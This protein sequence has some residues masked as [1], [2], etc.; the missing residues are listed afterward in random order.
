MRPWIVALAVATALSLAACGEGEEAGG[1][2][3]AA[4]AEPESFTARGSLKLTSGSVE[5]AGDVCYGSD[6]F[7]DIAGGAQVVV[8]DAAGESV[9]LGEL[10]EGTPAGAVQCVFTF[11]VRDVPA[12]DSVY[13][14]EVAG[15]GEVSFTPDEAFAL[16]LTLG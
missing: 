14:A 12:G 15:R 2:A 13:S 16:T 8:R 7:D 5:R 4:E 6:G 9:A 3:P 10:D 1:A 11:A